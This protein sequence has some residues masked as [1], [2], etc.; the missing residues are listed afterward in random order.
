[1]HRRG[2]IALDFLR[3]RMVSEPAL[4]RLRVALS[5]LLEIEVLD[6][7]IDV[8]EAP[9]YMA[10][11]LL[12]AGLRVKPVLTHLHTPKRVIDRYGWGESDLRGLTPEYLECEAIRRSG[13]VNSPSRLLAEEVRGDGCLPMRTV[14]IVRNPLNVE[15][16]SVTDIPESPLIV[17]A[18][19]LH[20]KKGPELILEA[21]SSL[22]AVAPDVGAMFIGPDTENRQGM[23][24]SEWL[25]REAG[26]LGVSCEVIP[27]QIDRTEMRAWYERARVVAVPS[28]FE[29]FSMVGAEAMASGRP[30]VCSDKS[31][32]AELLDDT[33]AGAVFAAGDA[34]GLADALRPFVTD[35]ERAAQAGI[36]ARSLIAATCGSDR[37]AAEKEVEYAATIRQWKRRGPVP[38]ALTLVVAARRLR[39]LI[40]RS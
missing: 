10:E 19:K 18:G 22:Q 40:R 24:Y 12:L 16:W 36:A 34:Q 13:R 27:R 11:G 2:L 8:I 21:A 26:S 23:A 37:V 4:V 29:G 5:C 31:G 30:V 33:D 9:D 1:V 7:P 6:T 38:G 25:R 39:S 15:D 17:F 32:I 3:S 14:P 20:K 35:R 28:R